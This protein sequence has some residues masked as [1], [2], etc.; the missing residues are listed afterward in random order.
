M[1]QIFLHGLDSSS[2]GTK[3][4]FFKEKFPDM[5]IPDFDGSLEFRL[6]NLDAICSGLENLTLIGSSF[7][8][9][10]ATCFAA[11]HQRR[12]NR[13]YLLAPALNFPGFL[14]PNEKITL[15]TFLLIGKHDTVTPPADVLPLAEQTFT[16]LET[17][18]VEDDHLLHEV[19]PTFDWQQLLQK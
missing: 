6:Q 3:A 17:H 7:G 12:I 19:F 11:E 1:T 13:L 18:L 9:L 4:R 15:P 8:G 5:I 16:H 14:V 10:M 2:K